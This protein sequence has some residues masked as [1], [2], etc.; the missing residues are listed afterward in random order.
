MTKKAL[1]PMTK[2]LILCQ[3]DCSMVPITQNQL[4]VW[5]EIEALENFW[6]VERDPSSPP[7]QQPLSPE[8]GNITQEEDV[9][10]DEELNVPTTNVTPE[11]RRFTVSKAP[12]PVKKKKKRQKHFQESLNLQI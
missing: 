8:E 3:H 1:L 11:G 10:V 4:G 6:G 12:P 7:K 2:K 9:N 5:R